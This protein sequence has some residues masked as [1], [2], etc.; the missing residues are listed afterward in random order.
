M[1]IF[2][3]NLIAGQ[4]HPTRSFCFLMTFLFLLI[5]LMGCGGGGSSGGGSSA[6]NGGTI[7][8]GW[9]PNSESDLAGYRVHYGTKSDGAF[10]TSIDVGMASREADLVVYTITNLYK[11]QEYCIALTA[12]NAS[13]YESGLSNLWGEICG[14]AL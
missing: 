3:R 12:Y 14:N 7:K 4:S 11:G 6:G 9:D 10:T 2:S 5:L 13:N 1:F 8:I